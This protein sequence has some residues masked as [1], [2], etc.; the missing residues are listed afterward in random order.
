MVSFGPFLT[1]IT[2]INQFT[3]PD[4]I[5]G[6][7]DAYVNDFGYDRMRMDQD[8]LGSIPLNSSQKKLYYPSTLQNSSYASENAHLSRRLGRS[9]QI[10]QPGA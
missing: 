8:E 2:K 4:Y 6:I 1:N 7:T 10:F 3:G 9:K 5:S